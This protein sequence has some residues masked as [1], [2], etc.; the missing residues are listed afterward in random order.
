MVVVATGKPLDEMS[1][2]S[3]YYS[4]TCKK[5]ERNRNVNGIAVPYDLD[6]V[7]V[8]YWLLGSVLQLDNFRSF[9]GRCVGGHNVAAER[10][11][12]LGL[13][14]HLLGVKLGEKNS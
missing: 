14:L 5:C 10:C 8:R 9:I 6:A 3:G 11:K 7:W 12:V 4:M 1:A 13:F 2:L